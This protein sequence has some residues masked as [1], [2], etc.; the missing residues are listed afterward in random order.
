MEYLLLQEI[1]VVDLGLHLSR[2]LDDNLN[3]NIYIEE[4]KKASSSLHQ[5][6]CVLVKDCRVSEEDNNLFLD[7]M[8][9]YFSESDGITDARPDLHYQVGVT[10]AHIELPRNHCERIGAYGPENKPLSPCPPELDPK[11]RFFWRIGPTPI[12][13]QFPSQNAPPVIPLHIPH[14]SHVMDMWGN[15]MLSSLLSLSEMVAI[16][17]SLPI[18]SFTSL[19]SVG[20]HLLAP[21]GSD[22]SGPFGV[23]GTVLAGYHYDL[24]FLT[25]HGKARFPG[26][27]IWTRDGRKLPVSVPSG[28]LLVQAGKQ[29]E[30]LTG[31]HVKAGFHEV[32]VSEQ[33]VDIIKEREKTKKSLWRVSSTCFSHINSDSSLSPLAHFK[34]EE[35]EREYPEILAG[36][37]VQEELK[38]ISLDKIST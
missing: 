12:A 34:T 11:W 36:N 26:L 32:V 21:T 20:P 28:C 18:Q 14:W 7:M 9:D 19:M 16:G 10:P 6:G 37:Q 35:T 38:A 23:L 17:F 1:P 31:G 2:N 25:I 24:N 30:Y 13:T 15:K 33:T 5:F 3:N 27:F 22:L 29:M 8:E 4:C